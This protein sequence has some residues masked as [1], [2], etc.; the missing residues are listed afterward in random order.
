MT[1]IRAFIRLICYIG[2][3]Q[4]KLNEFLGI[5]AKSKPSFVSVTS[6]LRPPH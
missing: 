3:N 4:E 5:E 2:R 1:F 6:A